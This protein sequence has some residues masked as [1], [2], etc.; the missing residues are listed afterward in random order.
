VA[1]KTAHIGGLVDSLLRFHTKQ[2]PNSAHFVLHMCKF[3]SP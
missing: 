1:T 2:S 3:V